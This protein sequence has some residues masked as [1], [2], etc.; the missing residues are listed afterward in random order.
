MNLPDFNLSTYTYL[1]MILMQQINNIREILKDA[2]QKFGI[3][4]EEITASSTD[5]GKTI[6]LGKKNSPALFEGFMEFITEQGF[7][8][9]FYFCPSRNRIKVDICFGF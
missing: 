5:E 6:V 8:Y 1:N 9:K 7:R 4:Y 2:L 3:H